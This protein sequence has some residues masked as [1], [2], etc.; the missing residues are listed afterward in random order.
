MTI[1]LI[2]APHDFYQ[3]GLWDIGVCDS[4]LTTEDLRRTLVNSIG[5]IAET[6]SI[7]ISVEEINRNKHN[8]ALDIKVRDFIKDHDPTDLEIFVDGLRVIDGIKEMG[9]KATYITNGDLIHPMIAA[10]SIVAKFSHDIEMAKLDSLY[11]DWDFKTHRG[12]PIPDHVAMI[13]KK[14]PLPG[15]HKLHPTFTAIQNYCK[16]NSMGIPRW[17]QSKDKLKKILC[18]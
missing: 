17:A 18:N 11:P 16:K 6:H 13:I 12:Y 15:V 8:Q 9:T 2:K 5:K 3:E 7:I 14:K 4:K 10:A 1:G